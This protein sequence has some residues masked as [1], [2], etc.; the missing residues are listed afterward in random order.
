MITL[1]YCITIGSLC[2]NSLLKMAEILVSFQ[3]IMAKAA[4][5]PKAKENKDWD[6]D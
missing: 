4:G 1:C 3:I 2:V 6:E 5:G